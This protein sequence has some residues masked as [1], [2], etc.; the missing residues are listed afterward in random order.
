LQ[1]EELT[2]NIL[3]TLP[4]INNQKTLAEEFGFSIGKINYVIKALVA[5]GLIKVE[6]FAKS[7]NKRSYRYLLTT[8][9]IEEK[10]TLTQKFVERKKKE[11]E[12]LQIELEKMKKETSCRH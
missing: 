6:N 7:S 11:Y 12:E 5:K 9:G 2:L 3:R 4:K 8:K 1:N 10:I